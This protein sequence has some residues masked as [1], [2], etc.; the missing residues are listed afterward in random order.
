MKLSIGKDN[1]HL[2]SVNARN[3]RQLETYFRKYNW[4]AA[5]YKNN[6]RNLKNFKGCE[7]FG[8]DIDN[9]GRAKGM[10]LKE[11]KRVFKDYWHV[12][13]T[14]RSHQK[15]KKLKKTGKV[16]PPTDRYRVVLRLKK[17]ITDTDTYYATWFELKKKFPA[18]DDQCKD[19][20][21]MWFPSSKII[22]TNYDG[23]RITPTAP[24]VKPEKMKKK[25]KAKRNKPIDSF[26]KGRVSQKT[27]DFITHG[28]V[29]GAW[30]GSLFKAAVDLYEQGYDQDEAIRL[31]KPA[32]STELGNDGDFDEQDIKTIESAFNRETR[33]DPRTN[34]AFQFVK[35]SELNKKGDK[36]GWLL[37]GLLAEGELSLITGLP[38]SGKSTLIRQLCMAVCRGQNFLKRK[39]KQG[40]VL[41]LALEES[42]P[43][44]QEQYKVLGMT[45][46]DDLLI[47]V[48]LPYNEDVRDG[49][50]EIIEQLNPSLVVVD[51]LGNLFSN[52]QDLNQYQELNLELSKYRQM[53]RETEAHLMFIHHANK[54]QS[55]LGSVSLDGAVDR[56]WAFK[57]F[58][59]KRVLTTQGRGG[60]PLYDRE[61]SFDFKKQ[62]YTL[63]TKHS[64]E[65]HDD[66]F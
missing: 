32:T 13:M 17:P 12:I 46:E 51:T 1:V 20:S 19:P 53:I 66:F 59:R 7:L 28:E 65:D 38:K 21:R 54:Q 37:N 57:R 47:H 18:I 23:T 30:N 27:L 10:S 43:I 61:L 8:L 45:D 64:Y 16:L 44:L 4:S 58:G 50:K 5:I 39:T 29:D 52:I 26:W 60:L 9:D 62:L 40:R 2:K 11:A 56:V 3:P 25:K 14:S 49:L 42:G 22:S 35:V 24:E 48:G 6:Y 34:Q 31:L 33:Y 41:Y 36:V 63:G 15:S 55:T